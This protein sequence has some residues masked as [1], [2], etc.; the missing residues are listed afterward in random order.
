MKPLDP[1]LVRRSRA[2]RRYLVAGVAIG[3]AT[4]GAIIAQAV[5]I[6][7]SVARLFHS[8][9]ANGPI[10]AVIACF[11][12]RAALHWTHEVVAAR[13]AVAVKTELRG[14]IVNDLLDPRRQGP[15]PSS[16]RVITL[17]GPGLDSFDGYVGRFLPQLVLASIVPVLIIGA[18]L[19]VDPLSGLIIGITL[20]LSIVFMVLIGLL[21]RD[22]LDKRWQSLERLGRHFADVLDGLVVLKIFGR[23]QERGLREVGDRHRRETVRALR[24]AFLSSLVLELVATL[25]VAL[26]AVSVGLRVVDG[27]LTLQRALIVLLLAPEAYLPVRQLGTMF[28]DS[29]AGAEAVGDVLQLLDHNRHT[30][31]AA[32]PDLARADLV[33]EDLVVQHDDR[34]G[35]ALHLDAETIRPGEFVA[36]T[37]PSGSGKSTLFDVMLGFIAPASGR[38]TAG[39]VDL[40]TIDPDLWRRQI[41]WV[42]QFPGLVEGTVSDNVRMANTDATPAEVAVALRDVGAA[43]LDPRRWLSESAD[44]ISAGERRRI[45]I[46]RALLRVRTEGAALMLLDEPTAGLDAVRE[47]AVLNALRALPVTVIVVAHRA[48]IIA[49]ADRVLHLTARTVVAA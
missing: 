14:E 42:P 35:P 29:T 17:L 41:A 30:G 33:I 34:S 9:S 49:A 23:R 47:G 4:T 32:P 8:E 2:V 21:T 31:L 20:P 25:S 16:S 22:T 43:D 7:V 1:R 11:G 18:E 19:F 15:A 5:L 28:H 6:A 39:G 45:A 13:S 40:T 24:V 26:V 37:G 12:A 38:V 44:D 10:L 36:V 48:E 3:L 27:H 46:A